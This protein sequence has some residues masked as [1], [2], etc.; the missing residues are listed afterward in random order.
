VTDEAHGPLPGTALDPSWFA[1]PV[2]RNCN[3]ARTTPYCPQCGQKAAKR[4]EWRDIGKES[5]DRLRYF[6]LKSIRTVTR[7]IL[8]PGTVARNYVLGR[9]TTYM[10]PLSLLIVLVGVLVLMLA[11]NRYFGHYGFADRDVDRMA[12]RVMTY[13][14]WSFS[15]GIVSIFLGSW[16]VFRRRLGYN[17]IEHAVLAVFV[18]IVILAAIIVNMVPTLI[19]RDPAFVTAHRAAS[20]HYLYVIK[21]AIV[22][23]A[24]RQF[25]LLRL[26]SD[27]PRLLLACLVFVGTSWL[28]LRAYAAAI[29][30]LVSRTA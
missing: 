19:W 20:Q 12:K 6:E 9:R 4:F 17:A 23:V 2:C 14:N 11:A 28:L 18:Q 15:L 10:H 25:F 16:S 22:A 8:S 26:R 30:W 29:L 21:L 13:A 5:W 7:L 27:W 1:A 24:Y 3:A